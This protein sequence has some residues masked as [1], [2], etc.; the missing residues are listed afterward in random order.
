M[1][2]NNLSTE[3]C[4]EKGGVAHIFAIGENEV[5]CSDGD[6]GS[7]QGFTIQALQASHNLDER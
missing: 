4:F 5:K 3:I 1:K 2:S 7:L 6:D